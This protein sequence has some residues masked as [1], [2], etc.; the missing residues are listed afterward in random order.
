MRNIGLLCLWLAFLS[1]AARSQDTATAVATPP[2][3]GSPTQEIRVD[4]VHRVDPA[5]M[6]HR[7]Y[8]RVPMVGSGKKDDPKRPMF[9]PLPSEISKDHSGII[10]FQM[11]VSD[12]GKWALVEFVGATPKD[13]VAITASVDP[14]VKFFE[15]GK[16]T[17][18]DIETEF[19]KYKK[20]FTM[21]MFNTRAQ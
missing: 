11:Q 18:A 12:D 14:N 16:S 8:A 10:A 3:T 20:G 9:V 19:Q 13:L 7:V 4:R 21:Q 15:R 1:Q 17:Q 5:Q 2:Y 6:Y